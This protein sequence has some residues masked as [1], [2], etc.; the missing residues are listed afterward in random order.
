MLKADAVLSLKNIWGYDEFRPHQWE[1]IENTLNGND[2]FVLMATGQGKSICYMMPALLSK[3]T[4]IVVSP[5]IA[6]MDDQVL[7]LNTLGIP[8]VALHSNTLDS[9]SWQRAEQGEF[10]LVYL[11]PERLMSWLD[12]METMIQKNLICMVALDE[13]HCVSE[14]GHDFRPYYRELSA[15]RNRFP[16]VPIMTL[17]AT[18]TERVAQDIIQVAQLRM[19]NLLKVKTTFNRPNLSYSVREKSEGT[20]ALGDDFT[21]E[22]IGEDA[23]IVYCKKRDDTETIAAHLCSIGINAKAYHG[24]M[25]PETKTEIHHEFLRDELQ[26]VVSTIAFGMGVNKMNITTVIHYGIS[27]SLEEYQQQ[28]GRAG[29]DGSKARC[30]L[31]TNKKEMDRIFFCVQQDK[32]PGAIA[33][34]NAMKDYVNTVNCRRALVLR[35][36]GEDVTSLDCENNCDNCLLNADIDPDALL[37]KQLTA[38]ENKL[39][40]ALMS[41]LKKFR[42]SQAAKQNVPPYMI[43][44]NKALEEMSSKRPLTN[45]QLLKISGIGQGKLD[46]YGP[47][48]LSLIENFCTSNG[49]SSNFP[50]PVVSLSLTAK[51]RKSTSGQSAQESWSLHQQGKTIQEIASQRDLTESTVIGH[52]ESII[53]SGVQSGTIKWDL[54]PIKDKV[55]ET[56]VFQALQ[57]TPVDPLN[58]LSLQEIQRKV[59]ISENHQ[60]H[61]WNDLKLIRLKFYFES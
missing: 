27:S 6:L 38:Q 14:W 30:I 32:Q 24:K 60:H 7:H 35:Y 47:Q 48:L 5:L 31:F 37:A 18:A 45:V 50:A 54:L 53:L 19:Q 10:A 4:S 20:N 12:K 33:T 52:L 41:S 43:L 2:S 55:L 8:A 9:S 1:A 36:F 13:A 42:T 61:Q 34:F 21:R 40:Q 58:P 49:V 59:G 25:S 22:V 44:S 3:R 11:S 57:A 29:R 17:T 46:K 26:V 28:T 56:R 39:E 16:N 23:C 15:I 51:K